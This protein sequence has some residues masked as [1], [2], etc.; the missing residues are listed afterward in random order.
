VEDMTNVGAHGGFGNVWGRKR[1]RHL[2]ENRN[3]RDPNLWPFNT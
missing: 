2:Y 3:G 1:T